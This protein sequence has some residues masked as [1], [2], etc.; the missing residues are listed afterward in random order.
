MTVQIRL[1]LKFTI[2]VPPSTSAAMSRTSLIPQTTKR[3]FSSPRT[4]RKVTLCLRSTL[5]KIKVYKLDKSTKKWTDLLNATNGQPQLSH[6]YKLRGEVTYLTD[7]RKNFAGDSTHNNKILD[8][9]SPRPSHE[10]RHRVLERYG[11]D[12]DRCLF[13][14]S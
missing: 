12:A 10:K 11:F 9:L 8:L 2:L 3:S 14:E 1:K 4:T 5:R 6:A 7:N 13:G